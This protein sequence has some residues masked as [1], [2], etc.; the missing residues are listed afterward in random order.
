MHKG[1][2]FRFRVNNNL[3]NRKSSMRNNS[4]KVW[5]R[6]VVILS[7]Y[8]SQVEEVCLNLRSSKDQENKILHEFLK[9][10]WQNSS[11]SSQIWKYISMN[12]FKNL[13]FPEC[14]AFFEMQ[15]GQQNM[16]LLIRW[17]I[18]STTKGEYTQLIFPIYCNRNVKFTF[19][20]Y[21]LHFKHD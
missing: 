9:F 6:D 10:R 11:S 13:L 12:V 16:V 7:N 3:C 18:D 15:S 4:L 14:W 19:T 21:L 8:A 5:D 20:P 1:L 2:P 17:Q